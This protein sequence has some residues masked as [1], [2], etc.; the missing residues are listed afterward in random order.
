VFMKFKP[1]KYHMTSLGEP[2]SLSLMGTSIPMIFPTWPQSTKWSLSWS[3]C[4]ILVMLK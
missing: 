4:Q 1:L 3:D 2:S